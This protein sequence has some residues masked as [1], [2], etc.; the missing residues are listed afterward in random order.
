[1]SRSYKKN[2]YYKAKYAGGRKIANRK[3][4]RMNKVHALKC[5]VERGNE[6]YMVIQ[7]GKSHRKVSNPYD[8]CEYVSYKTEKEWAKQKESH[9]KE[10]AHGITK[11]H[12]RRQQLTHD[13]WAILFK[14][15]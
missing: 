9:E 7:S 3:A 14:R 1:M 11:V 12:F 13:E 5:Q 10:I 2:P 4:R 15:K 8:V 6:K